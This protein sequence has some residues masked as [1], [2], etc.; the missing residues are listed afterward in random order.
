M[1]LELNDITDYLDLKMSLRLIDQG[2][3]HK[4]AINETEYQLLYRSLNNRAERLRQLDLLVLNFST[5]YEI[6]RRPV[7]K[8][9]LKPLKLAAYALGASS[10]YKIF[11]EAY[12]VSRP[13]QEE[14]F[15]PFLEEVNNNEREYID[16]LLPE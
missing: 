7:L 13:V 5:Y 16:K 14:V 11:E 8:F 2:W 3:R 1:L 6:S 12:W 10:I 15:F 9:L 4:T